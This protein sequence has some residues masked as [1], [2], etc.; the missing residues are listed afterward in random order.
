MISARE[1]AQ[2]FASSRFNIIALTPSHSWLG[3]F[4]FS[5][6]IGRADFM[7]LLVDAKL[8]HEDSWG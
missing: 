8:K 1:T 6:Q 7:R 3:V 5:C 2:Q 4:A